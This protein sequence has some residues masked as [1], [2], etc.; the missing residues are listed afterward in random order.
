MSFWD[1]VQEMWLPEGVE[2]VDVWGK[3]IDVLY[4]VREQKEREVTDEPKG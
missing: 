4:V 3:P 1:G 2:L